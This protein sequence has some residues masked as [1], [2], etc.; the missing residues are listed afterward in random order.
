MGFTPRWPSV[1]IERAGRTRG[2]F[3]Q[4]ETKQ[5]KPELMVEKGGG[6]AG[7]AHC[8]AKVRVRLQTRARTTWAA[9]AGV[10]VLTSALLELQERRVDPVCSAAV[11][12]TLSTSRL[13]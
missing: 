8:V 10:C 6:H 11:G 4:N 1:G 13:G 5:N 2:E 7:V 12:P 3:C 9:A